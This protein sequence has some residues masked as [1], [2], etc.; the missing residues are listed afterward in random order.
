M[1]DNGEPQS[2]TACFLRM[3]FIHSVK[4][5]KVPSLVLFWYADACILNAQYRFGIVLRN[6]DIDLA[7]VSIVFYGIIYE[8]L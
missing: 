2:S 4:T 6:K 5:L 7:I 8:F 1:F 3:T